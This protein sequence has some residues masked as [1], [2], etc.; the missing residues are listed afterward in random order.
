MPF[1]EADEDDGSDTESEEEVGVQQTGEA[2]N[3]VGNW[4]TTTTFL[5]FFVILVTTRFTP[6]SKTT[7]SMMVKTTM[8]ETMKKKMMI[9]SKTYCTNK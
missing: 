8:A 9:V 3:E 2:E 6:E 4:C 7:L 5:N 1:K